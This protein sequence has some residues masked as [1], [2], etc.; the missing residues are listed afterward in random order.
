MWNGPNNFVDTVLNPTINV[1]GTYI[2]TILNT[3]NGC[4]NT[5]TVDIS[6]NQAIP[7]LLQVRIQP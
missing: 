7:T 1:G 2:I 6:V 3:D 4:T 5:D